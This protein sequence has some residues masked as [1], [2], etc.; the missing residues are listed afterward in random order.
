MG[1]IQLGLRS[2]VYYTTF[3]G[4]SFLRPT[5]F[6]PLCSQY[7]QSIKGLK[8]KGAFFATVNTSLEFYTQSDS[9]VY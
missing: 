9:A 4:Y 1:L 2:R 6:A 3:S 8:E 7:Q 5:L